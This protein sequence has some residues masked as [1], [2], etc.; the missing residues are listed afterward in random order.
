[1]EREAE[2]AN[3]IDIMV[4]TIKVDEMKISWMVK[5]PGLAQTETSM[6]ESTGKTIKMGKA[7][8]PGRMEIN[9]KVSLLMIS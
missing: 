4:T 5:V 8:T 2:Q 3:T 7:F 6:Q 1:M 9:V